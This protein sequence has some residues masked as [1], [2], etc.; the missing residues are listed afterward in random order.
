MLPKAEEEIITDICYMMEEYYYPEDDLIYNKG[1]I[2]DG[3]LF[4]I[5]GECQV[6]LRSSISQEYLLDKLYKRCTYGYHST[7][8]ILK[9]EE[10]PFPVCEHRI[11]SQQDTVL[12]KLPYEHLKIM[13]KKSK[14][15]S[16]IIDDNMKVLPAVD[17]T[18]FYT[19]NKK[20]TTRQIVTKFKRAVRRLI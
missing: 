16:S 6:N 5:E 2:I 17:F 15:L 7:L 19:Y 13:R 18:T 10:A 3:V 20:L 4:I 1:D 9:D 8:K 11:V 14:L 12:L